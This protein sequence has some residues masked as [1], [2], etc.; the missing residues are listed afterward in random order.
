MS[1]FW[2]LF[3]HHATAVP[4]LNQFDPAVAWQFQMSNLIQSSWQILKYKNIENVKI[5]PK[6]IK[7]INEFSSAWQ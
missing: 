6:Y 2:G 5:N 4:N 7:L 1:C 3:Q